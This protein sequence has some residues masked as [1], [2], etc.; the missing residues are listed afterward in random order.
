MP[1]LEHDAYLRVFVP[2][3]GLIGVMYDAGMGLSR[4]AAKQVGRL[5]KYG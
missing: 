3:M 2:E 5:S 4:A 1:H